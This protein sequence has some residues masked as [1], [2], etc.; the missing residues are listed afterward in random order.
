MKK[1]LLYLCSILVLAVQVVMAQEVPKE[2]ENI[3]SPEVNA[4][5]TVTFRFYAPKADTVQVTSDFLPPVKV[6]SRFGLVDGPGTIN[7]TKDKNGLWTYTSKPLDSE[8]YSYSFIVDGIKTNDP[9]SP[10]ALRNSASMTNIFIVDKGRDAYG[11]NAENLASMLNGTDS[12][13]R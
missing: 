4:D 11:R 9:N 1:Q 7:L 5:R 13:D 10:Y 2:L 12:S 3:I 8:L 6:M